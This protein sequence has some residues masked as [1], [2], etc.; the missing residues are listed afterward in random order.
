[1]EN[2]FAYRFHATTRDAW[3]AM[4]A[5]IAAARRSI[6][7][8]VYIFLDDAEGRPFVDLLCERARAGVEVRL[9]LDAV[10]SF[11]FSRKAVGRLE[12]AGVSVE[13]FNRLA[14]NQ[15]SLVEWMRAVWRRSHGKVLI[16]DEERA[17]LGGVNITSGAAGWLDLQLEVGGP[18]A[19]RLAYD[20]ARGFVAAGGDPAR[21]ERILRPSFPGRSSQWQERVRF[22]LGVPRRLSRRSK[23]K[24]LFHH[25]LE[26]ANEDV[27]IATPYLA[28][29]RGLLRGIRR[30]SARGVRVTLLLPRRTDLALMRWVNAVFYRPVL[31]CGA[32]L[33]L[34]PQMNHAKAAV[35]DDTFGM[36]GSA[37]LTPRSFHINRE[38]VLVFEE[39]HMVADLR[40]I[41]ER[42]RAEGTPLRTSDLPRPSLWT[43]LRRWA[44]ERIRGWV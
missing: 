44:V 40:A 12:A 20:F 35:A 6:F 1:M 22:V 41:L 28:P 16:V 31:R 4:A 25:A 8:E 3:Q 27:I 32:A 30:A 11:S 17:F 13:F 15:R 34:L 36:V 38:A 37:N 21:V 18:M 2:A 9:V 24:R 10:G 33:V 19:A 29:D 43:R 42:W 39:A 23:V 7:W 5:A 14:R 26:L